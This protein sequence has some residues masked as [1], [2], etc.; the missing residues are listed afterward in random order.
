V[1]DEEEEDDSSSSGPSLVPSSSPLPHC[2]SLSCYPNP[3]PSKC[4]EAPLTDC[5]VVRLLGPALDCCPTFKCTYN[6]G[7]L[8][9][10]GITDGPTETVLAVPV[11][12]SPP[13]NCTTTKP[14]TNVK[15]FD[16]A[17]KKTAV[18]KYF[19]GCS[20]IKC[21]PPVD[22]KVKL[23]QK[24]PEGTIPKAMKAGGVVS[25]CCSVWKCVRT[26][27]RVSL[28]YGKA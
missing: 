2:R 18:V 10:F 19:T 27:E 17:T 1:D 20:G 28:H 7:E 4:S 14:N 8:F 21:R 25:A 5:T 16:G 3:K 13:N 11:P 12:D 26:G 6:S 24:L 22:V 9:Q 23:C 15:V